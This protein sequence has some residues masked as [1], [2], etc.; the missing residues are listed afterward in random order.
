VEKISIL[1]RQPLRPGIQAQ[2]Q[3]RFEFSDLLENG[4]LIIIL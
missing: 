4:V 3:E 1:S 2:E